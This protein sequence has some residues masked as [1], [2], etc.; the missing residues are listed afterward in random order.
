MAKQTNRKLSKTGSEI[1][2]LAKK[3][4]KANPRKKWTDCVKQAGKD[5]KKGK[6]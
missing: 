3:I 2:S 6:R 4:R 1:M 5:W